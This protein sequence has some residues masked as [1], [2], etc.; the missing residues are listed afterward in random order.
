MIERPQLAGRVAIG[1]GDED[2]VRGL[3]VALTLDL[4]AA[5]A[6][7]RGDESV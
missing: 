6:A 4:A 1:P 7:G 3:P 2:S 5:V